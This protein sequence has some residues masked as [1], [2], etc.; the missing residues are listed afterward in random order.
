MTNQEAE[1]CGN[2]NLRSL[3]DIGRKWQ[4]ESD[5]CRVA[6]VLHYAHNELQPPVVMWDE[7]E[8][9]IIEIVN[10]LEKKAEESLDDNE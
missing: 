4:C 10:T 8:E 9:E 6:D 7:L 1:I 3:Y 5:T 2:C